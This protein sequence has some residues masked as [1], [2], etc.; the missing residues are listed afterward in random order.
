MT[1]QEF[2]L[3]V[4]GENNQGRITFLSK[5][6]NCKSNFPEKYLKKLPDLGFSQE[7]IDEIASFNGT[8]RQIADEAFSPE[9]L[10]KVASFAKLLKK[11][12]IFLREIKKF[13]ELM[14][15][16]E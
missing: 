14:R 9:E 6:E 1:A 15:K 4:F 5:I 16:A 7:E 3:K 10:E 11:E 13:L 8:K 2:C 12:K